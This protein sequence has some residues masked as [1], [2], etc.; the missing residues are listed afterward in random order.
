MKE[1]NFKYQYD[2][3]WSDDQHRYNKQGDKDNNEGKQQ[4]KA[5]LETKERPGHTRKTPIQN[6]SCQTEQTT[7]DYFHDNIE[8]SENTLVYV[9]HSLIRQ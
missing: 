1:Q 9:L 4:I 3:E 7:H 2:Q 8:Y 6:K 5:Q